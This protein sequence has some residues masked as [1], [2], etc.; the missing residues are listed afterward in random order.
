MPK[1]QRDINRKTLIRKA[2]LLGILNA[3]KLSNKSLLKIV[4]RRNIKKRLTKI[5]NGLEKK[6]NIY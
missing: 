6:N 4:N 5:F 1:N 3:K 2:R